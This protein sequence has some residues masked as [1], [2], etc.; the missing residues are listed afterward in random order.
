MQ[1]GMGRGFQ[2]R[3]R[4]VHIFLASAGQRGHAAAADLLRNSADAFHVAR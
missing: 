4:R 1:A 2:R 3:Q